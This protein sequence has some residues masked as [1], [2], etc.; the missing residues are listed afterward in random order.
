MSMRRSRIKPA[1]NLAASRRSTAAKS[2]PGATSSN[3]SS[4]GTNSNQ[5]AKP[6]S[7]KAQEEKPTKK[8]PTK[9]QQTK[10]AKRPDLDTKDDKEKT[11]DA[12]LNSS[13]EGQ[14]RAVDG[15]LKEVITDLA[16]DGVPEERDAVQSTSVGQKID[17]NN[18]VNA[19]QESLPVSLF[20]ISIAIP[21]LKSTTWLHYSLFV[22][23][24][25]IRIR[26][27]GYY[28]EEKHQKLAPFVM[29]IYEI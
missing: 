1:I 3:S 14:S 18:L 21:S 12:E 24:N 15:A 13:K 8:E 2:K 27:C 26:H 19:E 10:E 23:C 7:K 25:S 9:K 29:S 28:N 17:D 22:R 6:P 11:K 20:D 16:K 4:G 5:K